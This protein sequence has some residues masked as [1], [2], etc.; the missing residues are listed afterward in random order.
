MAHL[1]PT[2]ARALALLV[3]PL[4][5][6]I[7]VIVFAWPAARLAPRDLPVGVVGPAPA[8]NGLAANLGAHGFAIHRYASADA[9]RAAIEDRAVYGALLAGPDGLTVFTA[10]AASPNV[11]QILETVAAG[12][13]HA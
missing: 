1:P 4:L 10:S 6:A 9:A 7:I 3:P 2:R 8:T 12:A 13:P 11:A 5:I